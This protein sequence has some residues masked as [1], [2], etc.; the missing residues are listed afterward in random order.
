MEAGPLVAETMKLLRSSIP[1]TIDIRH[2]VEPGRDKIMA[3]AARL[4]QILMNLCSNAA[5]AMREK[6]GV[7]EV[8]VR[9]HQVNED[10]S[11]PL[12]DLPPGLL[13]YD[14]GEHTGHGMTANLMERIFDPFF[15][16]KKPGE[17]TGMGLAVVHGIV[18]SLN[19]A[20]TVESQPGKGSVFTV[21]LPIVARETERTVQEATLS[22]PGAGRAPRF[23]KTLRA[24]AGCRCSRIYP[25]AGL[26]KRPARPSAPRSREADWR[27]RRH[28]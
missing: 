5:H 17:G 22:P 11:A 21:Y 23:S 1:A 12:P 9:E 2:R 19:G 13:P 16:T 6:G 27:D 28:A 4:Q 24:A 18:K 14:C 10:A 8:V 20:V 15:T 26:S 25:Q 7:I 3:D